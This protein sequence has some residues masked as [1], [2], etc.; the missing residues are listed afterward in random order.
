MTDTYDRIQHKQGGI[1]FHNLE[2]VASE[3]G[4]YINASKTN[5]AKYMITDDSLHSLSWN[6]LNLSRIFST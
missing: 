2:Q 1:L 4:L 6:K 3:I 5:M